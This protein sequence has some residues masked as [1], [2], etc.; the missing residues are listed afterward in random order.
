M[1][2]IWTI[3]GAYA[4]WKLTVTADPPDDETEPDVPKWPVSHFT[5]VAGHFT[6]AV[7][8]Y[9]C[10]RDKEAVFGVQRDS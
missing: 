10:V 6:D 7:N 2:Q 3:R 5:G 8:F 4:N 1:E 9:E